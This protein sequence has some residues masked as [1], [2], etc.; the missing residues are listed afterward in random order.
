MENNIEKLIASSLIKISKDGKEVNYNIIEKMNG[1]E[2][3]KCKVIIKGHEVS[4]FRGVI[5]KTTLGQNSKYGI[6]YNYRNVG[7]CASKENGSAIDLI[8]SVY[9]KALYCWDKEDRLMI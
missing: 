9:N 2:L 7:V 5:P 1:E 4:F 6:G 8:K 3:L